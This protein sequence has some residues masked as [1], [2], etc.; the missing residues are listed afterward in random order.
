MKFTNTSDWQLGK[1]FGRSDSEVRAAIADARYYV[2]DP[3]V[4]SDDVRLDLMVE[5]LCEAAER[6]QVVLFTCRERAFRHVPGHRL[7]LK[8]AA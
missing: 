3:L 8:A 6:M 1:P 2:V 4:Y 5:I 7:S